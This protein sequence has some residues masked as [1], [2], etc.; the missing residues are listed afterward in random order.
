[1]VDNLLAYINYT[2]GFHCGITIHAYMHIIPSGLVHPCSYSFLAFFS[3]LLS[4]GLPLNFLPIS[5]F[6]VVLVSG[7][8]SHFKAPSKLFSSVYNSLT[9]PLVSS[10]L[11]FQVVLKASLRADVKTIQKSW[12]HHPVRYQ[13]RLLF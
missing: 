4:N 7:H 12:S 11:C 3:P 5:V 6:H 1:M 9:T 10:I 8:S 2:K 13:Q